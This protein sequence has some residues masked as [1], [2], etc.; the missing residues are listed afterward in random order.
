[1]VLAVD[2]KVRRLD[3]TVDDAHPMGVFHRFSRLNGQLDNST[4]PVLL[5][6]V[7]TSGCRKADGLR[8]VF[9]R[10]RLIRRLGERLTPI[11]ASV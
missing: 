8:C 9:E 11:S 4:D 10:F 7:C 5:I 2:Q 6:A 3:V 1:M